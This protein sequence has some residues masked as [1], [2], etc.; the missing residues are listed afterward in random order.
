[1]SIKAVTVYETK[2]KQF[3]DFE[4]AV[5]HR[6]NLIDEF[7]RKLPGYQD[8]PAKSRIAFMDGILAGRSKLMDLMNY[9]DKRPDE[10]W[11]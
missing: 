10:G 9:D 5:N 8:M 1:M 7:L 6:E 2:G 4:Q 3:R 11:A